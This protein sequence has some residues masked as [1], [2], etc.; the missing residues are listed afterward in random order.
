MDSYE[1][2]LLYKITELEVTGRTTFICESEFNELKSRIEC[3]NPSYSI[4]KTS[5]P[6][7]CEGYI[8]PIR[9]MKSP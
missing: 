1:A 5:N 3:D 9:E 7:I 6:F 2:R 8:V 4:R